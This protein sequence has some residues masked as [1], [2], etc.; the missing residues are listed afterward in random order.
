MARNGPCGTSRAAI[1][2]RQPGRPRFARR[3][4]S[5]FRR[6]SKGERRQTRPVRSRLPRTIAAEKKQGTAMRKL[7]RE[8]LVTRGERKKPHSI[9]NVISAI[10]ILAALV[11]AH[12]TPVAAQVTP[13]AFAGCDTRAFLFQG[14]PTDVFAVDLVTGAAPLAAGD[15][16]PANINA[17]GYNPLDNYIY[18]V[19]GVAAD[20]SFGHFFRVGAD[21]TVQDLGV[22]VGVPAS[23]G[24]NKIGRAH[25]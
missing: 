16:A 7:D 21:F 2:R 9:R 11:F 24:F 10:S 1:G 22:P 19:S 13:P 12:A 3:I 25:V 15:I 14:D 5:R 20:P 23:T 6:C 8:T 4:A 18:G 17:V